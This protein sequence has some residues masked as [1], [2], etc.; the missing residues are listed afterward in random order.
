[1]KKLLLMTTLLTAALLLASGTM[2]AKDN[3]VRTGADL[4]FTKYFKLIKGKN[5]G[6]VTNHTGLLS[7]GRHIADV[8]HENKEVKLVALFGPE[9][10]V[11]GDTTGAVSDAVDQKTGVQAFSLY[12]KTYK[13]T[14][15]MMKGIDVLIYDIQDVGAR[16]YTYISTLG[17]VMEAAAENNIP[18]IVLDRPNPI[19]GVRFDGFVTEDTMKSFVAYGKI[20]VEHGMTVGELAKL[21]NGEGMLQ[22]GK[23][24]DLT[25]IKM[26]GWKRNMWYDQTGLKWIRTSPNLPLIQTAVVYPG[27]CFFEGLNISEGRGTDKPFE[28]IGA[29]WINNEKAA[30][31]LNDKKIKGVE[32][33]PVEFT[34]VIKPNNARPP[35]YNN[36]VC[37]GIYVDVKDRNSFEPVKAG[38]YLLWAFKQTNSDSIQWRKQTIDKLAAT[39]KLREMID[40]G[41]TA[42]EIFSAWKGELDGFKAVRQ[43]YLLYK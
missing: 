18:I 33:K 11:R 2:T 15:E 24:A 26:E 1:M 29:P 19:R 31:L 28:L 38:V 3:K 17:H 32:F 27:T 20:P 4:L 23:K 22:N 37:K 7:D 36:Q 6:L 10:G 39:P 21:Y 40:S 25:V 41:K 12:G 30:K 35:K 34:P 9:H 13:P 8:L 16:F 43:K 42:E 14:K 5:I